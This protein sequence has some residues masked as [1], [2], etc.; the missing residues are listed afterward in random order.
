MEYSVNLC[1][2]ALRH[3]ED[4]ALDAGGEAICF[5]R[6]CFAPTKV[7]ARNDKENKYYCNNLQPILPV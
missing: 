1:D 5:F 7:G 4:P 3:C 6:D 2:K